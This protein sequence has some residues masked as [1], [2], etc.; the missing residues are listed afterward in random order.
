MLYYIEN[1]QVKEQ[2]TM[3]YYNPIV[4]GF[5]PDPSV[6]KANGK[7]YMV[8]SSMNYFPGVPLFESDDMINWTNI[9]HCLTRDSQLNLNSIRSSGGIYA[10]TIRYYNGRFYM[11]T[12]NEGI[13][14][15]FYVYTDDIHGEWSEPILV[16]QGGI[17]PSLYFEDG[18]AY[19]MSN[20]N[21]ADGKPC[22]LQCEIDITTGKKLS[23]SV[24]VWYGTGGRYMEAPHLYKFGDY[25]YILN[26]EGGTEYGH[27]VNYARGTSIWGPFENYSKNPVLTNRNLGGYTLQGAGHGDIIEDYNGNWWFVHLAFRQSNMW[28]PFHHL[29]R[30]VCI[31]PLNWQSDGWFTIYNGTSTLQ[32]SL[33]DNVSFKPQ[34]RYYTKTFDTLN[35]NLDWVYLRN[36]NRECYVLNDDS[37]KLIGSKVDLFQVGSPTFI[38]IRQDEF[39]IQLSCDVSP[40]CQE[41]GVTMYMDERHHY[42]AFAYSKDGKTTVT[43]RLTIGRLSKEERS[44][45]VTGD[46]VNIKV[47]A[48][49]YTY[50]F[51]VNDSILGLADTRYLSTEVATGFT[52]VI[53]GLYAVDYQEQGLEATFT[54]L[55][56]THLE[57]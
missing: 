26:A 30:E 50:N 17:D 42:E 37:L 22:I 18:H 11:V 19:F 23:E 12:T 48:D 54:N 13:P 57:D 1:I 36:P 4:R 24:P 10:P 28:L 43:L 44:I 52:G 29:G 39:K 21:D 9:G 46:T 25:Y 32:V 2:I 16:D 51:Y 47:S 55:S 35:W 33:P 31:E 38:G 49:E 8:C 3:K 56:I 27:M 40:N 53:M 41:A 34:A 45:T 20:G 14:Q 15:N 5:Y 7:Y 6:C